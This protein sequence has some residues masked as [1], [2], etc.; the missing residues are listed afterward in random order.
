MADLTIHIETAVP[1]PDDTFG[2]EVN[3]KY[4]PFLQTGEDGKRSKST[5]VIE[6]YEEFSGPVDND[7]C[8]ECMAYLL[9]AP[10]R[11]KLGS[12]DGPVLPLHPRCRHY[13]ALVSGE[14]PDRAEDFQ[15]F[16]RRIKRVPKAI[17]EAL[18]P[19][20]ALLLKDNLYTLE[21][22]YDFS[23]VNPTLRSIRELQETLEIR[24]AILQ[25]LQR[26]EAVKASQVKAYPSLEAL[27][28]KK[29]LI[30]G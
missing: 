25:R 14:L 20:R 6:S 7:T 21:E 23:G 5:V 4:F 2:F 28:K 27:A 11:R 8:P 22:L 18:G 13:W 29:N 24:Q 15:E 16:S 30:E 1:G 12:E 19:K 10:F 17:S 9:P 3:G 26:G